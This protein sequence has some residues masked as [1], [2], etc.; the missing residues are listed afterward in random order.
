MSSISVRKALLASGLFA[1]LVVVACGDDNDDENATTVD[2]GADDAGDTPSADAGKADASTSTDAGKTDAAA[3]APVMCGSPAVTCTPHMIL[4]GPVAAGCAK[5]EQDEEVCGISSANVLMGQEP[6]FLEKNAPG[7]DSKSCGAF[8]DSLETPAADA[9]TDAGSGSI[10]N[11]KIDVAVKVAGMTYELSYSGCCTSAGYCSGNGT[12]GTVL[13]AGSTIP[14][15]NGYGC[16]KSQHFFTALPEVAP[17]G[18]PIA[19]LKLREV[20]CDPKTGEIKLPMPAVSDA[21]TGD[22]GASDAGVTDAGESDAG[23]DAAMSDAAT[24]AGLDAATADSG[25]DAS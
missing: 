25:S 1:A 19:G 10:G 17:A 15:D 13:L 22:A 7:V 8:Y 9:G 3:A 11:G 12:T 20:P 14:S 23:S 6:L 21:G 4:T 18:T 5:N 16:M 24:D 2:A